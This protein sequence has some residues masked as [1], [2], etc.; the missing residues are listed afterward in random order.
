MHLVLVVDLPTVYSE[1][2]QMDKPPFPDLERYVHERIQAGSRSIYAEIL[3]QMER[4]VISQVLKFTG[5]KQLQA[6][7]ILGVTRGRLRKKIRSLEIT[8]ERF[9]VIGEKKK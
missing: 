7:R 6:A 3:A 9:V 1:R 2:K 5:G 4:Q 8:I